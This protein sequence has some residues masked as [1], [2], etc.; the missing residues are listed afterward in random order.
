MRPKSLPGLGKG[1]EAVRARVLRVRRLR[2]R[3][4]TPPDE[5]PEI[6]L[7]HGQAVWLLSELGFQGGATAKTF[8]EYVKS[9]RKFGIPFPRDRRQSGAPRLVAYGFEHL[10]E[11][12]LALSL[13]VYHGLP[14]AVLVEL[15]RH[16][17]ELHGLYLEAYAQRATGLGAHVRKRTYPPPSTSTARSWTC[18]S[19]TTVAL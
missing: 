8:Y 18:R 1:I 11:L 17:A 2:P 3:R 9:L 10:M 6:R 7:R 5:T 13:R 16:R 14:D 4:Q 15:I 19:T 12:G